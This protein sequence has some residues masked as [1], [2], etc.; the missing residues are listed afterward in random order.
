MDAIKEAISEAGIKI[1]EDAAQAHG[2]I[3][4]DKLV[5]KRLCCSI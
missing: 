4:K 3:T 2:A 5:G 1:L